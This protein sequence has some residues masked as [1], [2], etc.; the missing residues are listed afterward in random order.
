MD[1]MFV[2]RNIQVSLVLMTFLNS[3]ASLV[4]KA[5]IIA[6]LSMCIKFLFFT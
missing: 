3:I 6:L 5:L 1:F 4:C 2:S